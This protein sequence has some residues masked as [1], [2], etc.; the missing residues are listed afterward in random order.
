MIGVMGADMHPLFSVGEIGPALAVTAEEDMV[1]KIPEWRRRYNL[2]PNA[3]KHTDRMIDMKKLL[4]Y[5][6]EFPKGNELTEN[7]HE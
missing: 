4:V 7:F 3:C 2:S 1:G 5:H 6:P